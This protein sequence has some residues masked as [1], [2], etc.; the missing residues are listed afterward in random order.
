MLESCSASACH[1]CAASGLP[2]GTVSATGSA[3]AT[4]ASAAT[5][6]WAMLSFSSLLEMREIFARCFDSNFCIFRFSL[7][8]LRGCTDIGTSSSVSEDDESDDE[9]EDE[10]DSSL[11]LLEDDVMGPTTV[12][13]SVRRWPNLS[14]VSTQD[15]L[16]WHS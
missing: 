16:K 10:S 9:E 13:A 6:R 14:E 4:A 5:A 15:S 3:T 8:A 2:Q 7:R 1:C 12:I 11:L